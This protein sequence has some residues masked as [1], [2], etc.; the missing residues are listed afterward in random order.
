MQDK[1]VF[2][3][4]KIKLIDC[5][6]IKTE[7]NAPENFDIGNITGHQLEHTFQLAF[8]LEEKL[9]KADITVRIQSNSQESQPEGSHCYFHFAFIYRIENLEEL[10]IPAK[11]NRLNINPSLANALASVTYSTTRGLLI[12]K[13]QGTPL[14]NFILP[15]IDPG[16]LVQNNP[17]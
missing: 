9:C 1:K 12:V 10:A 7:I 14:Q 6:T 15:V 3:P 17:V 11:N 16:K 8:N 2:Q 13:L 4:E 5:K